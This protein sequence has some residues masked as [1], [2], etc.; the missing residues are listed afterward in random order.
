M[1]RIVTS[2]LEFEEEDGF[3]VVTEYTRTHIFLM[4]MIIN[5]W[6]VLKEMIPFIILAKNN[7]ENRLILW[8][9]TLIYLALKMKK[10][11]LMAFLRLFIKM[12]LEQKSILQLRR[13]KLIF[14]VSWSRI[15]LLWMAA[16]ELAQ[17][18]S[19]ILKK[20]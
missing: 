13:R 19:W 1:A 20:Q 12:S 3:K 17:L 18:Y 16:R 2:A 9:L 14:C 15:I 5:A 11:N 8:S 6:P 4:I 7:E 10:E